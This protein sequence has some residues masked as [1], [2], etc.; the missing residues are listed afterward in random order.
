MAEMIALVT[1][2]DSFCEIFAHVW[3]WS[4]IPCRLIICKLKKEL[5]VAQVQKMLR[6]IL[7]R[8]VACVVTGRHCYYLFNIINYLMLLT[9]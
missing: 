4:R 5:F 9:S 6:S 7:E 8:T 1:R 3:D 2:S